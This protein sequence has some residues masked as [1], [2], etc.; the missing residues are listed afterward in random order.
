MPANSTILIPS[1]S[2][3]NDLNLETITGEKFK[4]AGFYGMGCGLHTVSYQISTFTGSI[5]C[6]ATLATDPQEEDWFD[7]IGSEYEGTNATEV[8]ITNFTGNFVWVRA[9]VD[10][11]AGTINRILINY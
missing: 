6:Q 11:T 4:A 3:A 9:V 5:K 7:V 8:Y 10:Y 2:H 1:N